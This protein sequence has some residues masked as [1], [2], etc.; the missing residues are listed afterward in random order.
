MVRGYGESSLLV[1]LCSM[2]VSG[3]ASQTRGATRTRSIS[4]KCGKLEKNSMALDGANGDMGSVFW[5]RNL[6]RVYL[7]LNEF[8]ICKEIIH[9]IILQFHP[10]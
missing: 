2:K 8:Q 5:K 3:P 1:K 10:T 4:K 9:L 6:E 7:K